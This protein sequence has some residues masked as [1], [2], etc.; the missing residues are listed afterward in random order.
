MLTL[1]PTRRRCSG[2]GWMMI[3]ALVLGVALL[4]LRSVWIRD[5]Y[6]LVETRGQEMEKPSSQGSF[7]VDEPATDGAPGP[8]ESNSTL[9]TAGVKEETTLQ[10]ISLTKQDENIDK[11]AGCKVPA[12]L[13]SKQFFQHLGRR[14]YKCANFKAFGVGDGRKGV[15]LDSRFGLTPGDCRVLSFGICHEWSF[16]D[17][18]AEFGC[19]VYAFDPTNGLPDHQR[20]P[21][22]R[23]YSLGIGYVKH[24]KSFLGGKKGRFKIDRY[25]NILKK[26]GMSNSTVDY[27]KM[28]VEKA[29]LGFFRDVFATSPKLLDNVRQIGMELH[30][31]KTKLSKQRQFWKYAHMLKCRGFKLMGARRARGRTEAVWGRP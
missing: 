8:E 17:A 15:C 10:D 27:L 30:H 28:D 31:T 16:D 24:T 25:E 3:F 22:V 7:G 2:L 6:G 23:F 26:L 5:P 29:E 12:L 11:P 20:S 9:A 14:E 19:K 13:S 4:N 21:N 1:T 18:M